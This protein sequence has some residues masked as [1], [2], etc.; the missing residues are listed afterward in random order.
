MTS[1]ILDRPATQVTPT[2]PEPIVELRD[3][4]KSYG[5]V[6]AL[7][8]IDLALYPGEVVAVLGPNGA[9]KTTAISL[10]LGLRPAT[11]GDVRVFGRAPGDP[12]VRGRVGAMLQESGVP[13]TLRV[14]ELVDL[15]RA[16]YPVALPS[17]D[18]LEAADLMA[19]RRRPAGKLSGG[20]RQRLYFALALAGDPELLFLDEPTVGMDVAARHA[21]WERI[22]DLAALGK[23]I[24]F[25]TH[26]LEEA[27]ALATRVVVID[28]GR[29]VASGS[30]AEVKSRVAGKRVRVRGSVGDDVLA[31]LPGVRDVVG[32]G[33]YRVLIAEDAMPILRALMALGPAIEEVTVEEA[34]LETAFLGLT[35]DTTKEISR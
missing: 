3:V 6:Q 35:D 33:G 2:T 21:F 18:V 24:L 32:E 12:E 19:E 5:A 9:G 10:M 27:D 8:G 1:T 15:F 7:A 28:H 30:P 20:Q 14:G 25:T 34:G 29:I 17:D 11:D 26:L 13:A 31:A 16:Y 22:R 23:T 4:R